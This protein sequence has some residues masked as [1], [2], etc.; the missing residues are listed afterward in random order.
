MH[1]SSTS[2][3]LSSRLVMAEYMPSSPF[4]FTFPPALSLAETSRDAG[5]HTRDNAATGY[6]LLPDAAYSSSR[7]PSRNSKSQ[8]L[9]SLWT[10]DEWVLVPD[11]E[12]P[13]FIVCPWRSINELM[14]GAALQFDKRTVSLFMNIACLQ[15]RLHSADDLAAHAHGRYSGRRA[16]ERPPSGPTGHRI[17]ELCRELG[18][19]LVRLSIVVCMPELA[20]PYVPPLVHAI[21]K[22]CPKLQYLKIEDLQ[23]EYFDRSKYKPPF[24]RP[25]PITRSLST[26]NNCLH[27]LVI[28]KRSM[29]TAYPTQRRRKALHPPH[30]D[31]DLSHHFTHRRA[32]LLEKEAR[33]LAMNVMTTFP[34]LQQTCVSLDKGAL[35]I[36]MFRDA[37]AE[38]SS[39]CEC[40]T[41]R[42]PDIDPVDFLAV[43]PLGDG[44]LWAPPS[45]VLP[46]DAEMED[47]LF[48]MLYPPSGLY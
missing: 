21:V 36:C 12:A 48:S 46:M 2:S 30:V 24:A 31:V 19:R 13:G 18:D 32:P 4:T 9:P 16:R 39:P 41:S 15:L 25:R 38:A 20:V 22:L 33:D 40:T 14:L 17:I 11:P 1:F 27:T 45:P 34:G 47:I 23:C 8:R 44:M 43:D 35:G 37:V 42:Q 10:P 26:P 5:A 6:N 7:S 29:Y 3:F 28:C